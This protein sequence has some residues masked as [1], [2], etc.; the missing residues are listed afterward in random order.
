MTTVYLYG[1]LGKRFGHRWSLDV[2]SP[3][4][5]VRAIVANQ[6][7]FQR[8]LIQ[9]STPGYQIFIGPDP[10]PSV[11]GLAYPVGQQ[12]IKI[13][14]VI[15]G[16]A[17]SGA[18]GIIIGVVI[19]AAAVALGPLGFGL[20]GATAALAVGSIGASLAIG[21]ISQLIAGTPQAPG[22]TERP[23]NT[24]SNIFNG[25][26]NTIA[27]GHPVPIGYGRLRVGSAVISAG[28]TTVDIKP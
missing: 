16:A 28:I 8:H 3:G 12:A 5:A 22:I 4:E 15:A 20:I 6:P 9:H 1:Q 2:A 11:E 23:E 25:P 18:L 10:I 26:V 14:P 21:G 27:Q 7:D 17:K 19:I 13:V 24:P